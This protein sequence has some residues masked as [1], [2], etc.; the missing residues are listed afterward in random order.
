MLSSPF[1]AEIGLDGLLDVEVWS[2]KVQWVSR[3]WRLR[4]R[5][6]KLFGNLSGQL[7]GHDFKKITTHKVSVIAGRSM[8]SCVYVESSYDAYLRSQGY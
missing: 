8:I 3:R 6:V 4:G 7:Q 2:D 5:D 1:L